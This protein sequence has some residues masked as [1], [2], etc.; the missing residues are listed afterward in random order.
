MSLIAYD[1]GFV[2]LRVTEPGKRRFE[3]PDVLMDDLPKMEVA[4]TVKK[5]DASTTEL[6]SAAGTT[7]LVTSRP[8]LLEL[9][10]GICATAAG[11]AHWVLSLNPAMRL[12]AISPYTQVEGGKTL[13]SLGERGLFNIEPLREK[14]V[15]TCWTEVACCVSHLVTLRLLCRSNAPVAAA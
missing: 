6:T 8:F 3:V 10:R 4:W 7:V 1:G 2:R 9:V 12:T 11:S 13:I 5:R 15:R 14:L